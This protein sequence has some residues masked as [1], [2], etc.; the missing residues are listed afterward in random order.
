[1]RQHGGMVTLLLRPALRER[2]YLEED[3]R[4]A[5][6]L[7]V[8]T[9]LAE[10]GASKD[11]VLH[12]VRTEL[13]RVLRPERKCPPGGDMPMPVRVDTSPR[14]DQVLEDKEAGQ[15]LLAAVLA[16]PRPHRNVAYGRIWPAFPDSHASLARGLGLTVWEVRRIE[17]EARDMLTKSLGPI[18]KDYERRVK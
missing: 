15:A 1:M 7:G 2:P 16:L 4:Q 12:L 14:P 18:L 11:R 13:N 6:A 3:L 5:A 8:L 9:G 10:P 17:V